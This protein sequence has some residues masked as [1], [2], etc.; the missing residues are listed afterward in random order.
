MN[1]N[2]IEVHLPKDPRALSIHDYV[3]V[4]RAVAGLGLNI[5]PLPDYFLF[6]EPRTRTRTEIEIRANKS[7]WVL[8]V[9]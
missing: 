2:D 9:D 4:M 8:Q 1:I 7:V 3:D 6:D 5:P